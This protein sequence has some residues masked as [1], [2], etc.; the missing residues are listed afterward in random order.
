MAVAVV[1][2][3]FNFPAHSPRIISGARRFNTLLAVG[4]SSGCAG[5]NVDSAMP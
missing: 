1:T 5:V 3:L 2:H 4:A